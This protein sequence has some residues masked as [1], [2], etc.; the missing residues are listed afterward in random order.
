MTDVRSDAELLRDVRGGDRHAYEAL[1][2]RHRR[3]GLRYAG[4]MS[5]TQAED[6]VSE[7][8]LAI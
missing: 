1:W 3:A 2:R 7:S 8:F 4:Q 5:A 6:L